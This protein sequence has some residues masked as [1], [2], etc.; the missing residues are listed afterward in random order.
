MQRFTTQNLIA[1]RWNSKNKNRK[2]TMPTEKKDPALAGG[3]QWTERWPANQRVTGFPSQ[4]T[5][6]GCK[7]RTH[8]TTWVDNTERWAQKSDTR[9]RYGMVTLTW[10]SESDKTDEKWLRAAQWLLWG[11]NQSM[12]RKNEKSWWVAGNIL[13][14]DRVTYECRKTFIT[15]FVDLGMRIC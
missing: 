7:K 12:R 1:K 9:G 5:C 10:P 4:D 6:L 8:E 11:C 13:Y 14:V 15:V 3:T 2:S